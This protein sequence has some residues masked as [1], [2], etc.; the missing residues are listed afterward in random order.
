MR[1]VCVWRRESDY[2]RMMEEWIHEFERRTG[3]EIETIDP[4]GRDGVGFCQS[5]D[6]VEYPT[7]LALGEDGA[8][9]AQW[10]GKELP[11]FDE[12]AYWL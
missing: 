3:K 12:V 4:D 10:R 8:V 9:L 6:I 7:I 1:V 11:L 2:G 5:Y